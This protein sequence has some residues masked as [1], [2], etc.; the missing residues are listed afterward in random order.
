MNTTQ[1]LYRTIFDALDDRL[2]K[3]SDTTIWTIGNAQHILL[4]RERDEHYGSWYGEAV[5]EVAGDFAGVG[6]SLTPGEFRIG[7]V[8]PVTI[9]GEEAFREARIKRISEGFIGTPPARSRALHGGRWILDYDFKDGPFSAE[10]FAESLQNE[11]KRHA[12]ALRVNYL[13]ITLWKTA[14]QVLLETRDIETFHIYSIVSPTPISVHE[15][16]RHGQGAMLRLTRADQLPDGNYILFVEA[17]MDLPAMEGVVAHFD[18]ALVDLLDEIESA[19]PP[20]ELP[21]NL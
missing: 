1:L 4:P 20:V 16:S 3:E 9:L 7:L 21:H 18:G 19:P 12:M 6:L 14:M 15:L 11:D 8:L 13:V 2:K 10:F 17:Q 5:L